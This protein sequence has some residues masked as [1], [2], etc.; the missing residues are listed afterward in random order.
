MRRGGTR[1]RPHWVSA[2]LREGLVLLHPHEARR[3]EPALSGSGDRG[4]VGRRGA[5]ARPLGVLV[6][7]LPGVGV[8]LL[9]RPERE[10][11]F[12]KCGAPPVSRRWGQGASRRGAEPGGGGCCGVSVSGKVFAS[13]RKDLRVPFKQQ[14]SRI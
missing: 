9:P 6:R 14:V 10:V 13:Q 2:G 11:L 3:L 5:A 7:G 4:G 8:G 1:R 12:Q